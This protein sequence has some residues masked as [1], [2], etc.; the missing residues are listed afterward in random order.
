MSDAAERPAAEPE[1]DAWAAACEEDLAAEKARRRAEHGPQPLS[2]TEELRRFADAV[3]DK[4]GLLGKPLGGTAGQAAAQGA[5]QQLFDQARAVV[6][7][8][9][10]RNPQVFDHLATAGGELL[11]AYRSAVRDQERRWSSQLRPE[12]AREKPQPDHQSGQGDQS[13]SGGDQDGSGRSEQRR[14]DG[15]GPEQIDLD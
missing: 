1:V 15:D 13:Q 5:A 9:V 12:D 7:P 6:E 10:Q 8:V 2:A 11:A 3:A 14:D 4:A